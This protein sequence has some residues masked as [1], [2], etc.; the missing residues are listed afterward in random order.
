MCQKCVK[1]ILHRV[2][3]DSSLGDLS[4]RTAFDVSHLLINVLK[5]PAK[6]IGCQTTV[7]LGQKCVKKILHRVLVDASLGDLSL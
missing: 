1:K 6:G 3:V 4:L 2:L 5:K 7:K